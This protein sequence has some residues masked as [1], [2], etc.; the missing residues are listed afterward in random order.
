[1]PLKNIPLTKADFDALPWH[2][3]VEECE[4]KEC[5]IYDA[6]YFSRAKEAETTGNEKAQEIYTLLGA[7]TSLH[8]RGD[9]KDEPFGP[10]AVLQN[11]RTAIVDDISD[12]HLGVLREIIGDIN[13]PELRARIADVIWIRLKDHK[14]AGIAI[15]AYLE[16][17]S[18][19]ENPEMWP[20]PFKRIERAFRIATQLGRSAGYW[21]KVI[22]YI[23][24]LLTKLGEN[25]PKFFSCRLMELLLEQRQGNPSKYASLSEKIAKAAETA[26]N[27]YKAR[28]YWEVKSNWDTLAGSAEA[29]NESKVYAAE[30]YAKEAAAAASALEASVHMQKSIEALRRVGGQRNVSRNFTHACSKSRLK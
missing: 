10:M 12:E 4:Q 20:P 13:D 19:L 23:E 14:A 21:A 29:S 11:S 2:G 17:A 7:I 28:A 15:D 3:V 30:T 25:D 26:G 6:K 16:S 27:Y 24:N 8:L 9:N 5:Y 1:M 22:Q 18:K